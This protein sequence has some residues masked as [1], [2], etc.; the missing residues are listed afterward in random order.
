MSLCSSKV[1]DSLPLSCD[2]PRT[3]IIDGSLDTDLYTFTAGGGERVSITVVPGDSVGMNF[4]PIWRPSR[5]SLLVKGMQRHWRP[6][7]QQVKA[8]GR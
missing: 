8:Y 4:D 3:G 2:S 1:C 7:D 5:V 6:E